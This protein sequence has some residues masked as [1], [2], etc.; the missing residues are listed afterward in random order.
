MYNN[1]KNSRLKPIILQR[2]FTPFFSFLLLF[3]TL[4]GLSQDKVFYSNNTSIIS[5]NLNG[6][7]PMT[8]SDPGNNPKIFVDASGGHI[9]YTGSGTLRRMNLD[10]SG[11]ISTGISGG[12]SNYAFDFAAGKVYYVEEFTTLKRANLDGTSIEDLQTTSGAPGG[13]ALDVVN[14]RVF[15]TSGV[16][17]HRMNFDGSGY[18]LLDMTTGFTYGDIEL[19]LVSNFLYVT[20]NDQIYRANFD[21]GGLTVFANNLAGDQFQ[22]LS[23]DIKNAVLYASAA[24]DNIF[25]FNLSGALLG[26]FG[27]NNTQGLG[28][29]IPADIDITQSSTSILSGGSYDFGNVALG[30]SS[31]TI[32]FDVENVGGEFLLT[33][34]TVNVTGTHAG[35]FTVNTNPGQFVAPGAS[36]SFS[37]TFTPSASG[38]RSAALSIPSRDP[39]ENP[40]IINISGTGLAPEIN[41]RQ[42]T[43]NIASGGSFDFGGVD[44]GKNDA[45]LF[46]IENT[47][48][49]NLTLTGG[50]PVQIGGTHSGDFTVLVDPGSPVAGANSTTFTLQFAPSAPGARSAT[51]TIPNN[52]SDEAPYTFTI[53]ATGLEAEINVRQNTTNIATGGFFDLGSSPVSTALSDVTFTIENIGSTLLT[54]VN[55]PSVQITGVNASDFLLVSSPTQVNVAGSE[56]FVIRATPSAAGVRTA[57]ITIENNDLDEAS[58]SFTIQVTGTAPEINL[59]QSTT[60]IGSGGNYNMGAID[61]GNNGVATFTVENTGNLALNLT[62]APLVQ[63]SGTNA[64]DFVVTANPSSTVNVAGSTTFNITFTP[65]AGGARSA[66]V[67]IENDDADE[68]T[69]TFTISGTGQEPEI[70][71]SQGTSIVSGGDFDFGTVDVGNNSG[72]ITF[73]INNT[74]DAALTLTDSPNYV[75]IGGTNPGDFTIGQPTIGT[76]AGGSSTTFT[77][78]FAPGG[79][80]AREATITIPNS[81]SDEGLYTITLKGT[82]NAPVPEINLR[83]NTTNILSTSGSYNFGVFNVGTSSS[84][85]TFT[86][87]NTGSATLNLG[88]APRVQVSGTHAADFVVNTQPAAAVTGGSNTTFDIT[89]TPSGTGARVATV[90]IINDD[91]DENP[92]TFTLTGSGTQAEID[93]RQG[94]TPLAVGSTFFMGNV[95][96]ASGNNPVTFTIENNGSSNL[97]LTGT[98]IVLVTG[99]HPSDFTVTTQ[100]ASS[101][102][103]SASSVT[104][105]VTF[106]PTAGGT[107]TAIIAIANDDADESGYTI[108]LTGIG[109]APLI[110]VTNASSNAITNG[111]TTPSTVNSTDF[112]NVN[113]G[114]AA[115]N[116]YTITNSGTENLVFSGSPI[117]ATSGTNAGDFSVSFTPPAGN[118]LAAGQTVNFTITYNAPATPGVSNATIT[119]GNNSNNA[120]PFTFNIQATSSVTVN[121]PSNLAATSNGLQVQLT[122]TD[123]STNEDEFIIERSTDGTTFTELTRVAQNVVTYDD[124][125]VTSNVTYFYRVTA[126]NAFNTGVSTAVSITVGDVL[127]P[128]VILTTTAT[129]D[130]AVITWQDV[131]TSET[132]Y[133]IYR[134]PV[135]SGGVAGTFELVFKTQPN[136]TSYTDIGLT[137]S[138]N[139]YYRMLAVALNPVNNSALTSNVLVQTQGVIPVTPSNLN[140]L[141]LSQTEIQVEWKDN[142]TNESGYQIFRSLSGNTG[143]FVLITTTLPDAETYVD[144]GL[145]SKTTYYYQIRATATSGSSP[146]TNPVSETTLSNAPGSPTDLVALPISGTQVQLNWIDNAT[147]EGGFIISRAVDQF[148]SFTVIDTVAANVTLFAD[149]GLTENTNYFYFVQ[150]FNSDGTSEFRTNIAAARTANVPLIP[151]S[152]QITVNSAT[153]VTINWV[154]DNAP[155]TVREAQGF[156]IEAANILG[157]RPP[158]GR[159]SKF[160]NGKKVYRTAEDEDLIFYEL[161]TTTAGVTSFD[162][163]DLIANQKYVFRVRAFNDNGNSPYSP[164]TTTVT[165]IDPSKSLPTAPS[166]LIA[167]SVS[168]SEIDISWQDNSDNE[169]VFKIERK[170]EDETDW[171]EIGQVIGGTTAFSSTNLVADKSYSYRV[172][173]SNE[174]GDS[175]YT[176]IDSTRSECNLLVLINNVSSSGNTICAG[177]AALLEVKTN[178]TDA[179]Y[180]W[181]R[182]GINIPNANLPVY[183]ADRTGEYDCQIISGD[184]RK[185]SS[186]PVIVIVEPS[187]G[188]NITMN[189]DTQAL[190][191]SV[192]GAQSYQWFRDYQPISG[193]IESSYLPPVDGVYFVVVT[194]EGC[195]ATSN[196]MTVTVNITSVE[197]TTLSKRMR[198]SPNPAED[199]S[200]LEIN[201]EVYGKYQILITDMQG[202]VQMVLDGVKQQKVLKKTLP[203]QNLA[204]GVYLIKIQ[205][206][207]QKGLQKLVKK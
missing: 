202:R 68:G 129:S 158:G 97:N 145:T 3:I 179:T 90:T 182:N 93:I 84:Q 46:T 108:N 122:W 110:G 67:T 162:A 31:T 205:L 107:R 86:I 58:Y 18:M 196:L 119:I 100:P 175:E 23:L 42:N 66:T 187:F 22:D 172:R 25:R 2:F 24:N 137:P 21:G 112:G 203:V 12:A 166:N 63:I 159:I 44:V 207:D 50:P 176:N 5:A 92:Y 151:R 15:W 152:V 130:E 101:T 190:E 157:I 111:S 4:D 174:G 36:T 104:F 109:D 178:V 78:N 125:T 19:D 72:N 51:I 135:L 197:E 105:V 201:N 48:N 148:G 28:V 6:S 61:V 199:E 134:A 89:F 146:F 124:A 82:G 62:G 167:E 136:E 138:T 65:G 181:K 81:D 8:V 64:A 189:N 20:K 117:I 96:V 34:Q 73:T 127:S 116:T 144:Q 163:S 154:L 99:L 54:F 169:L 160:A 168:Q 56:T 70:D 98:P 53:T 173:A 193:A 184:C 41:V 94:T 38:L 142:S 11:D 185:S 165:S 103:G 30:S 120:S 133:A 77:V 132:G 140:A 113:A 88:G 33:Q 128:P 74:G 204:Q 161:G 192:K 150:A 91:A 147:N 156:K 186:T 9:Y 171:T 106:D 206:K 131:N 49:S 191:S 200:I 194:N 139:Y 164:E 7:G 188:V 52:D 60:N 79:V 27:V 32:T 83:Q 149:T 75:S 143:T 69:Y 35:D 177:K 115:T 76:I 114:T 80:G 87:E 123:N 141:A 126:S 37:V 118:T 195:S 153:S 55:S 183:N 43:T 155:S 10:G 121:A 16:E 40:Y 17:M 47:G 95:S 71:V 180:Q 29:G 13:V 59:R 57:I 45:L 39:N 14:Q 198:L 102:L 170:R 85:T 26:D 1:I